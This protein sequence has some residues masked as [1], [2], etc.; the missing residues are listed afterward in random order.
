VL[1]LVAGFGSSGDLAAGYGISVTG[2]T[3]T[4]SR[5]GASSTSST[6]LIRVPGTAVFMTGNP[7]VVPMALL[8]NIKHNKTLHDRSCS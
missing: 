6:E 7:G 2:A 8:H 4:R 5:R 1:L 3:A